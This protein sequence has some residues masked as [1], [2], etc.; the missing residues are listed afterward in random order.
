MVR[1]TNEG[2]NE[3]AHISPDGKYIVWMSS[4]GNGDTHDY[5]KVGT[6]YWIM[7]ID[8]SN[9]QRLTFLN[10]PD[11]PHFRGR[12]AVVADFDWD[13][14]SSAANGYRFYAYLHELVTKNFGIP[15]SDRSA[16]GEYNFMVAFELDKEDGGGDEQVHQPG[17]DGLGGTNL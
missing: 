9:K 8:G 16:K 13:P 11:H 12:Y 1:L 2:Y 5:Y 17:Q 15:V 6:D 7:N 3:H 4:V 10:K 14:S